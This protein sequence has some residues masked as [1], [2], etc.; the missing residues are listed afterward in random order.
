[1]KVRTDSSANARADR[2]RL[3]FINRSYWPNVEA[4]GQLLTELCEDLAA[5]FDVTV[6]C[7]GARQVVE[8]VPPGAEQ[9]RERRG[10]RIR[11]VRHTQFNKASFVGRLANMLTF[12][13]AATLS[14]LFAQ[15]FDLVVVETDPP[16]LCLLGHLL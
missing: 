10:V 13:I 5:D 12:Q 3:L 15:R 14:A 6:I 8:N 16:F 4:T 2:P 11:R 7:G 1:M 9:L